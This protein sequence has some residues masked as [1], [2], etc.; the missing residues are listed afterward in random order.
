MCG[1]EKRVGEVCC[2]WCAA[3]D[4]N[5][6]EGWDGDEGEKGGDDCGLYGSIEISFVL[7]R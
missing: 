3:E 6:C 4:L 1:A 2:E 5:C 7:S